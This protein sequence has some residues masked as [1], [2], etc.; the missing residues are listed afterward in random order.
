MALNFKLPVNKV[1][2]ESLCLIRKQQNSRNLF[3]DNVFFMNLSLQVQGYFLQKSMHLLYPRLK[4]I[5]KL[6]KILNTI[7]KQHKRS[8]HQLYFQQLYFNLVHNK[9][10]LT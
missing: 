8:L 2:F 4:H 5:K 9:K 7:Y 3:K 6:K 1:C 10:F